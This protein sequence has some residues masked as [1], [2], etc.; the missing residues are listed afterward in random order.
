[1][2]PGN[3]GAVNIERESH[4]SGAVH[5]KGFLILSGLL[6]YALRLKHPMAF[7]SS[8]AFEQT[9]G[10]IDGDSASGAEFCCLISALTELPIR[11]DLA[12][13]GAVDQ[14]GN[15]LAIGAATEKIE[16]YFD[17]CKALEFTGTQGVIIPAANAD[18]LMVRHDIVDAIGAGEFSIYAIDR[19]DQA[20]TLLMET[21]AGDFEHGDYSEDSILYI[22]QQRAHEFWEIASAARNKSQD[23][24]D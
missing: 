6:R 7:S 10:G 4:L 5:T 21:D 13:T 8:I 16:G 3:S 9:Y 17:A 11:Q 12:M 14:K 18:E 19:I 22:A 2:G 15:I 24:S 1:M 20:M 23:K